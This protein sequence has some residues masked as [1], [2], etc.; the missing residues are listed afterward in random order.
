MLTFLKYLFIAVT[1][2][3]FSTIIFYAALN[4]PFVW[5]CFIKQ[6]GNIKGHSADLTVDKVNV[7]RPRFTLQKVTAE[8]IQIMAHR[9]EQKYVLTADHLNVP[10]HKETT[11]KCSN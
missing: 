9:G 10:M 6:I 1:I 11:L 2:V 7:K 4:S 8:Q 3:V 5:E